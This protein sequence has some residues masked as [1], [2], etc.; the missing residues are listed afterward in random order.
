M[1]WHK[2]VKAATNWWDTNVSGSSAK[3]DM[4]LAARRYKYN[5][6]VDKWKGQPSEDKIGSSYRSEKARE[7]NKAKARYDR[8]VYG[9]V[10]KKKLV[11]KRKINKM[12]R[13]LGLFSH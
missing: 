13:K 9:K 5:W 8:S 4:D 6:D 12:F 10:N 2:H 1:K 7:F 3:K 11:A